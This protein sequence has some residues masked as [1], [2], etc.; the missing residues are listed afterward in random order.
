MTFRVH[1]MW[2]SYF[3]RKMTGYL[4]YK[5]IAWRMC[6]FAGASP[7]TA[8]AGFPG[9]YRWSRR[10]RVSSCGTRRA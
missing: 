3:T 2:Q 1:G 4:D 5:R 8:A 7:E 10:P 6:R 9:A